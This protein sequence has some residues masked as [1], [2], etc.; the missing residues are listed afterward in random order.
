M[1]ARPLRLRIALCLAPFAE[2]ECID[3]P[4]SPPVSSKVI[5]G[6]GLSDSGLMNRDQADRHLRQI[7]WPTLHGFG[8]DRMALPGPALLDPPS[9]LL[10]VVSPEPEA[11]RPGLSLLDAPLSIVDM[12]S[13]LSIQA[14]VIDRQHDLLPVAA[15]HGQH[16]GERLTA[17][18]GPDR[19]L[20]PLRIAGGAHARIERCAPGGEQPAAPAGGPTPWDAVLPFLQA[21]LDLCEPEPV[22]LPRPPYDHQTVGVAYLLEHRHALLADDLG[23]GK[24]VTAIVAMRELF[25]RGDAARALIV[26]PT[27]ALHVW[28]EHLGEWAPEL[29]VALVSGRRSERRCAWLQPAHVCL[30]SY[31]ALRM[32][33]LHGG[34]PDALWQ[35][36]DL[37][38]A[39]EVQA[40]ARCGTGRRRAFARLMAR[41]RWG[42]TS[43][44]LFDQPAEALTVFNF[45]T[46]ALL[47]GDESLDECAVRTAPYVLRRR[48]RQ[49]LADLPPRKR[50]A[51]WLDMG[52]AQR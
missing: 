36:L 51:M 23:L 46:P 42:L 12:P 11:D 25:R 49:V 31:T 13:P 47:N 44:R 37:V 26:A 19:E 43:V 35:G 2:V 30:V 33:A 4:V 1:I 15:I 40:L 7:L 20:K 45:L 38:V 48:R 6:L 5:D 32:D 8:V 34:L 18:G 21:P 50:Q 14:S 22:T 27:S 9:R 52:L 41:R 16:Y 29:T 28:E 10:D 39:D 24:T 17:F 3:A